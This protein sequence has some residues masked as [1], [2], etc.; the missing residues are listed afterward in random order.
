MRLDWDARARKNAKEYISSPALAHGPGFAFSGLDDTRTI[1]ED[2]HTFLAED[3]KILEIGCGIGRL[4]RFFA[5]LFDQ[6]CGI[7]VSPEMIA[8]SKE[9]LAQFPNVTTY[10]GDGSSLSPFQDQTFEFVFSYVVFPHIPDK[11]IIREYVHETRRVLKPGG[12]FK[13]LVKYKAW[14]GAGDTPDT[15]NGVNISVED[16]DT[17][18]DETG[19]ELVNLYSLD[20][21]LA[22]ALF[23]APDSSQ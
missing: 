5:L 1:L 22:W 20:E 12:H 4:L 7:D 11:N 10:C 6:V 21:H 15:W 19:F 2:V 13:F 9:Y 17:W 14:D 16:I 3:S 18:R 23:R 8:Q